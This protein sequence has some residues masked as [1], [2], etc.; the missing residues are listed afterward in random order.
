[1]WL[2][3]LMQQWVRAVPRVQAPCCRDK[4]W[5][6]NSNTVKAGLEKQDASI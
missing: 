2:V 5:Q 1:M 3:T 4:T 6:S